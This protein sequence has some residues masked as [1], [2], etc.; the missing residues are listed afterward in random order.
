M[1]RS[2]AVVCGLLAWGLSAEARYFCG[3]RDTADLTNVRYVSPQGKDGEGCGAAPA[4]PCATIAAGI[5]SCK[6]AGCAVLVAFG[7]YPLAATLVLADGISLY[8]GCEERVQPEPRRVSLIRGAPQTVAVLARDIA[9]PTVFQAF[10]VIAG[11]SSDGFRLNPASIAFESIRSTGLTLRSVSLTGGIGGIGASAGFTRD[12][13]TGQRGSGRDRPGRTPR[14]IADGGAGGGALRFGKEGAGG[15]TG[16]PTPGGEL[17]G[18]GRTGK[19]GPGG[20]A[21]HPTTS[22]NGVIGTGGEWTRVGSSRGD[23]GG[24]GAGGSGGG[25]GLATSGGSGGAGGQGGEGGFPGD[26]GGASI[27]LLIFGGRLPFEGGSIRGGIGGAGGKGG[28]GGNGQHGGGG[29]D[30]GGPGSGEGGTGGEGGPGGGG[31]GGNGGPAFAVATAGVSETDGVLAA[32]SV[33]LYPGL[34]GEPGE[35]RNTEGG[36]VP[37]EPGLPGAVALE[38]RLELRRNAP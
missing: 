27:G 9:A 2:L 37:G 3:S 8:G 10:A 13:G 38:Q 21:G 19:K 26:Q 22:R 15:N 5:A 1:L 25:G 17:G 6:G 14:G 30:A 12:L 31:P 29:A 28:Y 34:G 7:E 16:K 35:G 33:G 11:P 20:G 23:N 36:A 24:Y 32:T 4:T 18:P